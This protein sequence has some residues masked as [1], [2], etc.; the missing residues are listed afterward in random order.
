MQGAS[1]SVIGLILVILLCLLAVGGVVAAIALVVY[2][3]SRKSTTNRSDN[4]NLRPCPDCEQFVSVRATTCP[5][6]G[7]PVT[8]A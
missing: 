3:L 1:F 4:P 5:H 2:F 6:C 7:G 8:S